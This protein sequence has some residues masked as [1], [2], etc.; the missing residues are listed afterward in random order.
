MK[1]ILKY[2]LVFSFLLCALSAI[3][4]KAQRAVDKLKW[5]GLYAGTTTFTIYNFKYPPLFSATFSNADHASGNRTKNQW[6]VYFLNN[7][8]KQVK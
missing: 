6:R 8:S 4:V 2:I 5:R 1:K 3:E 7:T